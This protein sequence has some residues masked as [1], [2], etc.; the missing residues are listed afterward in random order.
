MEIDHLARAM[1]SA[2]LPSYNISAEDVDKGMRKETNFLF[3]RV[4]I[5]QNL[6]I[7]YPRLMFFAKCTGQSSLRAPTERSEVLFVRVRNCDDEKR[8][9]IRLALVWWYPNP[10]SVTDWLCRIEEQELV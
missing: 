10:V 4:G 8:F 3:R 6:Q 2:T 7:K 9:F 1:M 5:P